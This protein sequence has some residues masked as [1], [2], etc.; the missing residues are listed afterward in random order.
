VAVF[1]ILVRRRPVVPNAGLDSSDAQEHAK[2]EATVKVEKPDIGADPPK[3][4]SPNKEVEGTKKH[5]PKAKAGGKAKGKAK[6][7]GK[8][9]AEATGKPK[10]E[11]KSKANAVGQAGNQD[12]DDGG[13]D[14]LPPDDDEDR[15]PTKIAVRIV[16][17]GNEPSHAVS[18]GKC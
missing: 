12:N 14:G 1:D 7:K 18:P 6:S 10:P 4:S 9:R 8:A 11:A 5:E 16:V 15:L 2:G 13:D 17:L 3:P